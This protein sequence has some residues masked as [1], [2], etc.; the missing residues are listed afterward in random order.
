M[1]PETFWNKP[2]PAKYRMALE[3]LGLPLDI[4]RRDL[5][6]FVAFTDS[7]KPRNI[8]GSSSKVEKGEG[9]GVLTAILYLSPGREAG[10]NMCPMAAGCE[11]GCLGS[12]SR[13][14]KWATHKRARVC[15]TIWLMLFREHFLRRLSWEIIGHAMTAEAMGM[16]PAIRLNGSSDVLW[17]N[18]NVPQSHPEVQFYD[19]TKLPAKARAGVPD[20]YHLT[21]SLCERPESKGR[22]LEWLNAGRNVAMVVGGE[23]TTDR[24]GV[25]LKAAKAAAAT[26]IERGT[27]DG[28]PV[29]S[30]DDDDIRFDDPPGAW[31]VLYA[32]SGAL[33]D[34]TGFVQRF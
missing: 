6:R 20:N 30:G 23:S 4:S 28:F 9:A 7:G 1:Y 29:V 27:F 5:F 32:K 26:I 22:A 2:V 8:L 13:R 25:M 18:Y 17:E 31:V 16:K 11:A 3:G 14:M 33:T 34:S 21:F 19:Y 24:P 12:T 15:K 10:I